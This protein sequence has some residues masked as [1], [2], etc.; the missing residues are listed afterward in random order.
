MTE[1]ERSVLMS[2]LSVINKLN[3]QGMLRIVFIVN[4]LLIF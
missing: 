3:E 2:L 4:V 1:Y